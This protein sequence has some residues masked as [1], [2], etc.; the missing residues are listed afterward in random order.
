M[1]KRARRLQTD[2][3][4]EMLDNTLD[5]QCSD[6]SGDDDLMMVGSD[7]EF[8]DL[9]MEDMPRSILD[10]YMQMDDI[11]HTTRSRRLASVHREECESQDSDSDVD[12]EEC[13]S[14]G[15]HIMH[16]ADSNDNGLPYPPSENTSQDTG[17]DANSDDES[18]IHIQ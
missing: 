6:D 7:D 12:R 16:D 15:T 17:S 3:V 9:E 1:S 14:Q 11:M 8:S 4:L 18:V 13:E 5:M 2:E 10:A